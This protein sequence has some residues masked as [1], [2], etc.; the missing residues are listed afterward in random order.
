VSLPATP[1]IFTGVSAR[2]GVPFAAEC[3][4][5]PFMYEMKG[6]LSGHAAP[7]HPVTRAPVPDRQLPSFPVPVRPVAQPPR[8]RSAG[9]PAARVQSAGYP[10]SWR[11]A[12]PAGARH[13][14]ESRF[15]DLSRAPG[16]P[17][18]VPVS[19][20]ECISTPSAPV[21]QEPAGIHFR[22][23]LC[24]HIVHRIASVIR[25]S[26][27]LSTALCTTIPQVT[28]RNP[29]NTSPCSP[30]VIMFRQ[31][32]LVKSCTRCFRGNAATCR[33]G[34]PCPVRSVACGRGG[35]VAVV[36]N[37]GSVAFS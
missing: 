19:N 37:I 22:L 31:E 2:A 27:R 5:A 20:G 9:C 28:R 7:D 26:P 14:L 13:P 12:P 34:R 21:A 18:M 11:R 3:N 1:G 29:K 16:D 23:F 6:A 33:R 15:P 36:K 4:K 10:A 25:T 30:S 17:R 35:I 8:L 32:R 24:P